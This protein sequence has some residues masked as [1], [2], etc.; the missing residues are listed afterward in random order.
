M[1]GGLRVQREKSKSLYTKVFL[2]D[3]SFESA[4]DCTYLLFIRLVV[5]FST[6]IMYEVLFDGF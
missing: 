2:K 6:P 1:I 5:T 3:V 4:S